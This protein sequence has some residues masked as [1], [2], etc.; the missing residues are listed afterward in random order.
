MSD[1]PVRDARAIVSSSRYALYRGRYR[2]LVRLAALIVIA[3]LIS[4]SHP[5]PALHGKGLVILVALVVTIGLQASVVLIPGRQPVARTTLEMVAAAILAAYDPGSSG[6]LLVF[7]GL[8]AAASL[9]PEGGAFLT[10]V[11][12]VTGVLTTLIASRP[13][14]D[15]LYG[16]AIVGGFLLGITIREYVLRVENSELRLADV[17]RAELE[18][19]KAVRLAERAAAARE[20]HDILAH[21]LGAIVVQLDVV[22][23]L[24]DNDSPN[25]AGI[26]PVLRDAHRHAVDGLAEVRQAVSSLREDS[27][28]VTVSLRQLVDSVPQAELQIDGPE[29]D[30]PPDVSIVVRRIAQEAVTNSMKHAPGAVCTVRLEFR[31]GSVVLSVSDGGRPSGSDPAPLAA[32]GGGYGIEGMKERAEMIGAVLTTG[33]DGAGWKVELEVPERRAS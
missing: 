20:I 30:L 5:Y 13:L 8:D 25:L 12:V 19:G 11:G 23:A 7:A 18:R 9:P 6:A 21:N 2:E 14:A 31:A 17:Q 29:R 27:K 22:N 1:V 3:V 28:P 32:T 4:T 16:L 24:L 15:G 10:G 33:P 26:R